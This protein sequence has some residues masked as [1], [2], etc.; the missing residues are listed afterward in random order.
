LRLSDENHR[1]AAEKLDFA[2]AGMTER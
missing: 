2:T 1:R